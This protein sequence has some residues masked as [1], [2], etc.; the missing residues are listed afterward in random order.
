MDDYDLTDA[1]RRYLSLL[2]STSALLVT[3]APC[4]VVR[5]IFPLIEIAYTEQIVHNHL[6]TSLKLCNESYL[7]QEE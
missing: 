7:R 1:P 6:A 5:F 3:C 4:Y 2:Q